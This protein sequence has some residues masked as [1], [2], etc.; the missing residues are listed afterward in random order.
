MKSTITIF[1][2]GSKSLK[3]HRL[4]LKALVNNINGENRLK[5]YPVSLSM[6][7]YTNLGDNQAEYDDFIEHKSDIAI[8][9]L[10]GRM[11]EKT[12]EEFLL[13]SR[14]LKKT[15]TPK[16]YVFMKEFEER[17]PQIEEIEKLVSEHSDSYYVEY[18][19]LEDLESKVKT[20]LDQE[21]E[22]LVA[23]TMVSPKK[24]LF[25]LGLWA[26]AATA[27]GIIALAAFAGKVISE[28][29]D[30]TLLFIGGGSAVNCLEEY[31][32]IG[33]IYEYKEAICLS[34][35]TS[36]SWP[37]ISSDVHHRHAMR[38]AENS[39]LFYPVC[40]SAMDADDASFLKMSN[41][42]QFVNKGAV[43]CYHLGD[44]YLAVY[45]KKGY[46]NPIIDGKDS[47]SVTELASFLRE[48]SKEHFM[49]FTTEEG[50]GT[51][52]F[53]QK[54]LEPHGMTVSK[55]SLGEHVDKFT[56]MT[57][58]SKIRRDD[59]PY[60]MLG[61]RYYVAKSVYQDGDCRKIQV[62]EDDGTPIV[63]S[64]NLYFA[65]YNLDGGNSFWIPDVMVEFLKKLD[66]RFNDVIKKNKIPRESER[67]IVSMNELLDSK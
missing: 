19:N 7:S 27:V 6:F 34:V 45:V 54:H 62:L 48:V 3:E 21:V 13:A 52:T 50:S 9:L 10:E 38:G 35:P 36:V 17:T 58:K 56:D 43:L 1:V 60:M 55:A 5:D 32:G 37:I 16:I 57:P 23:S 44:D 42:E 2:S 40:L 33:N 29:N 12:K 14:A 28:R 66:P 22:E 61:S 20:R 64:I 39:K 15:G 51:L 49:I 31:E 47:I 25:R 63:K 11:G 53:Y 8:F 18:S 65:G 26:W 30:A 24:K 67:V 46:S 41:R 59:T 4:R